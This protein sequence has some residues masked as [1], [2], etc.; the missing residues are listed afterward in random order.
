M[1]I[2][3]ASTHTPTPSIHSLQHPHIHHQNTTEEEEE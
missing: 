2:I 1:T 3:P